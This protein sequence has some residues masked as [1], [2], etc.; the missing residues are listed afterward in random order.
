MEQYLES[1]FWS[2]L[3]SSGQAWLINELP[4]LLIVVI[5]AIIIFKLVKAF[6]N[7]MNKKLANRA[8]KDSKVDVNEESKRI[9]TVL[10]TIHSITKVIIWIILIMI[11]LQKFGVNIGPIL[12]SFGIVGVAIGFGAQNMVRD[13]LSGFFIILENQ[14]RVSD[15]AI[16]NGTYGVVEKI[17]LRTTTLRDL[18]G[19]VHVFQNGK[20]DSVSNMTKDWSAIVFD[21]SV[22]YKENPQEVM[23]L[24]KEVGDELQ[25]D[26]QFKDK[27]KEP[28]EIFGLNEFTDKGIV[29]KARLK[30]K[31]MEQWALGREYRKRLF[32]AFNKN[33]IEIPYP[34]RTIYWGEEMKPSLT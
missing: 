18:S 30:T 8:T 6:L 23:N 12:A 27:I 34:H 32:D 15:F 26:S 20:I 21:I 5:I 14:I 25:N 1:N 3:I 10:R 13:Y 29:I 33:N 31:P 16:L 9:G 28:L 19:T 22:A 24:M 2:E 4:G 11:V 17:E 7:T